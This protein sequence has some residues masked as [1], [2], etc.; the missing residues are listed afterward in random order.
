MRYSSDMPIRANGL[1]FWGDA[2][3]IEVMLEDEQSER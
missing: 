3:P 1:T 2:S